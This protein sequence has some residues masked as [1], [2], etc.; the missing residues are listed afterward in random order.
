MDKQV[1][2]YYSTKDKMYVATDCIVF[3]FD[4]GELKL[5]IFKRRVEPNKGEWSLIGSFVEL[6]EDV[7]EAA[8]RVLKE[9]TGL[10]NVFFK[11]LKAYGKADRDKGYRCISIAQ[12]ALI[13]I[14]DYD[15][16]LV[17]KH[18]AFW[19]RIQDA[20]QLVM[21]HDEMVKD[22]LK[23]LENKARH[24][25]IGFELL[26][27]KFTI[28]QLQ[29]LYEAIYQREMDSRNFRKKVL[30][31]KVLKKLEEKDKVSSKRGAY[32]YKFD[33]KNYQKLLLSGYNFEI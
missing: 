23:E 27:Q 22:A 2:D 9:I 5:L 3:G 16:K 24:Q 32:L 6:E 8:R 33:Y 19:Y 17:E 21:D 29:S 20:P 18:G 4:E 14:D 28:P 31:L 30:S 13:R 25:P 26:P 11:Q 12:Y 1:I 7:D 10:D 15:K